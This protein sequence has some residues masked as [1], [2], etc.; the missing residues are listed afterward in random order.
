MKRSLFGMGAWLVVCASIPTLVVGC[1]DAVV[2]SESAT[3]TMS[4][5]LT[6]VGSTGAVYR[7]RN[8]VF[9]ITGKATATASSEDNVD[10]PVI[11]LELKAGGYLANLVTGWTMEKQN[12]DGTFANVKAV[13]VSTNPLPFEIIDQQ[14]T[15]VTFQ[16]KAGDDVVQLGN[17]LAAIGIAV[18]DCGMGCGPVDQ[19]GDGWPEPE[20]CDDTNPQV[21]PS[22]PEQCFD[23]LD[24][25]CD[26]LIDEFCNCGPEVCG[27]GIDN[28]CDG[29]VDEG[30]CMPGD[31]A[32]TPACTLVTQQGCPAGTSCYLDESFSTTVCQMPG[33]QGFN[34][35]CMSQ[36][37]CGAPAI[38]GSTDGVQPICL[39]VC[40]PFDPMSSALCA[41]GT[42]C[43]DVGT[44]AGEQVGVCF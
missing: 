14:L 33:F 10:A 20:D 16:F 35:P 7:L 23:M 30:C 27:D 26:G 34:Q 13:L 31:P 12:D 22:S 29:Q 2:E 4:V 6:G 44:I 39:Q 21:S 43:Q 40:D 1:G 32:C 24:N 36:A 38:C 37:E 9:K 17:D 8:G 25:N 18:D 3:G 41:P 28:S 15:P 19:D 5:A 42:T 11:Q